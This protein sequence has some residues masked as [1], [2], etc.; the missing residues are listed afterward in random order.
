MGLKA[1][2]EEFSKCRK[3]EDEVISIMA[4]CSHPVAQLKRKAAIL[5]TNKVSIEAART[6]VAGVETTSSSESCGQFL[7]LVQTCKLV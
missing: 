1:C 4:A 3:Y 6:K 7:Q 5:H 2:K